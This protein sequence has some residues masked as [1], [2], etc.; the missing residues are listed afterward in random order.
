MQVYRLAWKGYR[1]RMWDGQGA[2]RIGGR[3]TSRGH[4]VV[5]CASSMALAQLEWLVHFENPGTDTPDLVVSHA[6][7]ADEFPQHVIEASSLPRGW[8][9]QSPYLP[10]TRGIGDRW[11]RA[12]KTVVLRVPSAVSKSDWNYL[13]N[14]AHPDFVH[15]RRSRPRLFRFDTRLFHGR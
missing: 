3:W 12:Q 15:I 14:P 6:D 4:L 9:R 8:D 5:Y 1:S 7:I 13:L 11:C 2:K 10:Q